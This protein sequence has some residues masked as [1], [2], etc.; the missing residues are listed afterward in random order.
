M[1]KL[2]LILLILMWSS[3]AWGINNGWVE[4]QSQEIRIA[5]NVAASNGSTSWGNSAANQT[6][7]FFTN[8]HAYRIRQNA[9]ITKIKVYIAGNSTVLSNLD[10]FKLKIWR[11][12]GSTWDKIAESEN[13]KSKLSASQLNIITLDTPISVQEG[14]YYGYTTISNA[15]GSAY[16]FNAKSSTSNSTYLISGEEASD[17]NYNWAGQTSY[18]YILPIELITNSA[19]NFI[20]VGDSIIAGHPGHYSF[21]EATSTTS[22]TNNAWYWMNNTRSA[23]YQNMGIGS[24]TSTLLLARFTND[25]IDLKPNYVIILIGVNDLINSVSKTTYINNMTSILDLCQTNSIKPI[26]IKILPWSNGTAVQMQIRDDWMS[27]LETLVLS[28]DSTLWL[29]LDFYIGQNRVTGDTGNLWDINPAYSA[30]GIHLNAAGYQAMGEAIED[31][32]VDTVISTDNQIITN[33]ISYNQSQVGI[34]IKSGISGT[35]VLNNNFLNKHNGIVINSGTIIKNNVFEDCIIDISEDG[36]TATA[37]NNYASIDSNPFFV[38]AT[39][40]DFRLKSNSPL[41]NQGVV[42]DGIG[43]IWAYD[44]YTNALIQVYDDTNNLRMNGWGDGVDIGAYT[45]PAPDTGQHIMK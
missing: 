28:Y 9:D 42:V 45:F 6:R 40:N 36:G 4:Q 19:P 33:T 14:D 21:I 18:S 32:L 24:N 35:Y 8:S 10:T 22:L 44:N 5:P 41:I 15:G 43:D 27:D 12:D 38:N 11:Y 23:I 2:I 26:V 29:D 16:L 34:Y 17:L 7:D 13:L 1:K 39:S 37:S 25:V 3:W 31:L 20:A 30:D